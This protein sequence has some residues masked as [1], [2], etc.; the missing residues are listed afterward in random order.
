M[1]INKIAGICEP[2]RIIK[3]Y[4]EPD[5]SDVQW[6]GTNAVIYPLYSLPVLDSD[7]VGPVMSITDKE[8]KKIVVEHESIPNFYDIS[9]NAVGEK[10]LNGSLIRIVIGSTT[11]N[12]YR[13]PG[14]SGLLFINA[15]YLKPL[16]GGEDDPI[17]Y[18]REGGLTGEYIAAKQGL[19]LAAIIEP[20][21]A[22]INERNADTADAFA[23]AMQDELARI[24]NIPDT[25]PET[26]EIV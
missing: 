13:R 5:G 6:C 9:D 8:M 24:E 7:T 11:Y 10:L 18:L 19:M 17:L 4:D 12:A 25:D 22:L 16:L 1:K 26:G 20:E 23:Q 15:D 2:A 14:E 21:K 3:L